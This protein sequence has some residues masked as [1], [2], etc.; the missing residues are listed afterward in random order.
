MSDRE[1]DEDLYE[2]ED[3]HLNDDLDESDDLDET[4]DDD[5]TGDSGSSKGYS[6]EFDAAGNVI[7]VFESEHG[8]L[9]PEGIG[10]DETYAVQADGSIVKTELDDGGTETTVYADTNGDGLYERIS[11]TWTS[12]DGSAVQ[13]LSYSGTDGD[14][15]IAVRGGNNAFGGVGSDDFVI[16]EAAH[17]RIEDFDDSEGDHLVFDTGYGLTKLELEHYVT[18]LEVSGTD[19]IVHFGPDVSITLVGVAGSPTLSWDDVTV[20]S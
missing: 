5:H 19:L 7:A 18:G 13:T 10:L 6:F 1:H 12:L 9:Q 11:E 16:R 3:D 14:D 2:Q 4:E 20:L 15:D 8:V 17:L